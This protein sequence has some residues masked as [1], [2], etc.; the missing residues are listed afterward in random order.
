MPLYELDS[1][2]VEH[3][4]SGRCQPEQPSP[5]K[6]GFVVGATVDQDD[7]VGL[8]RGSE[9]LFLHQSVETAHKP[10]TPAQTS[11][12]RLLVQGVTT[13]DMADR[14]CLSPRTIRTHISNILDALQVHNKTQ[15]AVMLYKEEP[16]Q[17]LVTVF[18]EDSNAPYD[19]LTAR[20][21]EISDMVS[22]GLASK[23]IARQLVISERTVRSHIVNIF[24]K[25][26]LKNRT[27]LALHQLEKHQKDT[28]QP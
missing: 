7:T 10:L 1:F 3:V 15:A 12:G 8:Q 16:G 25:L 11:I 24:N 6:D 9:I 5:P 19:P 23:D 2:Y 27:Q 13:H 20:E 17:R 26:H 22:Q 21:E 18:L 14:L 4:S 28:G